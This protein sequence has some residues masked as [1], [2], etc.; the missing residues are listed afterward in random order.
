VTA[1]RAPAGLT[2]IEIIVAMTLTVAVFAITLPFLR[3]QTEAIGRGASRMDADQ[4]A[5][6]AVTMIDRD[7]RRAS[8]DSGQPLLV[9][10]APRALTFTADLLSSSAARVDAVDIDTNVDSVATLSWRLAN[11][12]VL[13]TT[14]RSFPTREYVDRY[15]ATSGRETISYWLAADT[16]VG[17]TDLFVLWRRVNG[18]D[19]TAVVRE[20]VLPTDTAFFS[21]ERPDTVTTGGTLGRG[22]RA[23]A[24]L[25]LPLYWDSLAIDSIRAVS[26]RATG[27]Y[28]DARTG[29]ETMSTVRLTTMLLNSAG[30]LLSDCGAAPAP[31]VAG[32]AP[33]VSNGNG[34]LWEVKVKWSNSADDQKTAGAND[35]RGYLLEWSTDGGTAWSSLTTVVARRQS[36][37]YWFHGLPIVATTASVTANYRVKA[38]DCGGAYSS[39]VSI[40]SATF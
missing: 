12:V 8:A 19:S 39:A 4:V 11:A 40:G 10:A 32:N 36:G 24:N 6:Y 27:R 20:L 21:Y 9:L 3:T 18:G 15:G 37:Y 17:R 5:R 38:V 2:L 33:S 22:V 25:R 23:I 28:R 29:Q 1:R 26:M 34:T 14:A 30:R 16:V 35:V 31:P 7:L 13:P